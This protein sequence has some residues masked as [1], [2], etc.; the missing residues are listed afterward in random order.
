MTPQ[1]ASKGEDGPVN[2][3]LEGSVSHS[4]STIQWLRDQ[5]NI[6]PEAKEAEVLASQTEQNDGLY[7]VP[8][9]SGLFAPFWRSDARG[10]IVGMTATHHKGHICRAALEAATYQA[11]EVF[12]AMY[13][14]SDVVLTSLRVDGGGTQSKLM[15]QHQADMLEVPVEKPIIMETTAL[16]A[17]FGAGLATGV[18][19]DLDEIQK[20][21]EVSETFYPQ[22]GSKERERNW[23]GWKKAVDRSLAWVEPEPL[24]GTVRRRTGFSLLRRK[25]SRARRRYLIKIQRT[26]RKLF[27]NKETKQPTM[28]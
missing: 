16:G 5:L 8:A 14:D 28:Q 27:K 25:L 10:C 9:F 20:F 19:K 4:G 22:M 21:W 15:M 24:A 2:Y 13:A 6:I 18:W 7:F 23:N 17:A 3:A 12:D 26:A 1:C 11:R